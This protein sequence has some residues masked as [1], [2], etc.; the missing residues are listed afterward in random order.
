MVGKIGNNTLYRGGNTIIY[1]PELLKVENFTPDNNKYNRRSDFNWAIVNSVLLDKNIKELNLPITHIR[2]SK[3]NFQKEYE[4]IEADL[5]GLIFYRL[6]KYIS[7]EIKF[8]EKPSFTIC[9][10]Y[11]TDLLYELKRKL[12]SNIVRIKALNEEIKFL[13]NDKYY[14]Y[15]KEY[16]KV[17]NNLIKILD[18]FEKF[19]KNKFYLKKS[20]YNKIVKYVYKKLE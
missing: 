13:L 14:E 6:F 2:H 10:K 12:F 19:C 5:I 4:K 7:K 15:Y 20:I 1:N 18:Y 16:K 8:N 3:M 11:L 9:K 17:E